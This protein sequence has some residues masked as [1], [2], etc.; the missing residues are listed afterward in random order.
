VVPHYHLNAS[1]Q[2]Q[3]SYAFLQVTVASGA[4]QSVFVAGQDAINSPNFLN[5]PSK[6]RV[7]DSRVVSTRK[8]AK[9]LFSPCAL[10]VRRNVDTPAFLERHKSEYSLSL[11]A[12]VV[13]TNAVSTKRNK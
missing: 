6:L 9:T 4:H 1:N 3:K 10:Q 8:S 12:Q 7:Y 11:L 2:L 13:I 5:G